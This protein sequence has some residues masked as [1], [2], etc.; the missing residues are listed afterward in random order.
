M[1]KQIFFGSLFLLLLSLQSGA[2]SV[3]STYAGTGVAGSTDGP[4]GTGT[5]NG[6]VG[7]MADASG[8]FYVCDYIGHQVRKVTP[9]GSISTYAGSGSS[10]AANGAAASASFKGL[11][12]LAFDASGNLYVADSDDH[13]IRKITTGGVVSTYAGTGI[14]STVNGTVSVATFWNPTGLLF[15]ASGNLFVADGGSNVIR[16]ITSAG[17]VSTYAGIAGDASSIDGSLAIATFVRPW[18]ITTDAAG[19]MYVSDE[20]D[21]KIRKITPGGMVS[22]L[23]GS[24]AAGSADGPGATATFNGPRGLTTD[25][26]GNVYVADAF[27]HKIRKITPAGVV[28]TYAGTGAVGLANGAANLATFTSPSGLVRDALG[29]TYVV[30]INGHS[31]RKI[32]SGCPT[33]TITAT[34]SNSVICSGSSTTFSASGADTYTWSNGVIQGAAYTPTNTGVLTFTVTGTQTG[35]CTLSGTTAI[36]VTVNITPTITVNSGSICSGSSFTMAPSGASTYTYSNGSNVVSPTGNSSYSVTGTS[37]QGCMSIN[38][39]V[40]S[41]TV[42]ARPTVAVNSGSICSGSSFTMAPSGASTY[43]YSSGSGVVSP[44]GNTS[45]S[46][47]GTSAQGCL[48]SN[49]AISSV[50]VNARPTVAVNSGSICS[51]SSFTMAPSGASTYTYSGGSG[52]VAPTANASY[53]V[54]G[55]STQGC[56]SINTAV[57]SIT[58]HATPTVTVN[59]GAICSGTSFTMVPGGASTYTYSNGNAVVSPTMST[60]YS[61]TG[62]SVQGCVSS[63]TA[64]SS[65]TVN[66]TPVIAVNSGAI[67]AGRSFTMVPSGA[68][69][70]TFSNGNAV[71]SPT[72]TTS[73]SVTG[74]SA[75]GCAGS[76]MAIA[77]ITVNALPSVSLTAESS[78]VCVN[79]GSIALTGTPSGGIYSGANVSGTAFTP[80]SSGTFTPAYSFTNTTTGCSATATTAIVVN[81]CTGIETVNGQEAVIRVYPNPNSGAFTIELTEEANISITNA[82][83]SEVMASATMQAGKHS[84]DLSREATGIYFVKV[85]QN[86]KQQ[87]IRLVKQ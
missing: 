48:S 34:V 28:S 12:G 51:G 59:S 84:L 64:I 56:V 32:S 39:A 71:V 54:T 33:P 25:A 55:T 23:A 26:L 66:T 6:P 41:V 36:S 67:C 81:L 78:S 5:L 3:V 42:N 35:S 83:G 44:T 37:A 82:I 61:V 72:A 53:S 27:G 24:G 8:N 2:Q 50:T 22:T 13:R 9:T 40:S 10:G 31:I 46:I 43:T 86:H 21:N 38:T 65:V 4:A 14:N 16:K 58:V 79:S 60:T 29:D 20:T 15:D 74:T 17:M 62:T 1:K 45:Y 76:N 73:Y 68:A 49:T 11:T 7:L 75:Q 63:N 87:I 30:D 57:S 77:T 19:N 85:M 47:T 70:Y 69:T 52:V 80:V 18:G